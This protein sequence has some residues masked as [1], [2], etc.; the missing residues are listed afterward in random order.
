[1]VIRYLFSSVIMPSV[2]TMNV[3]ASLFHRVQKSFFN[4]QIMFL[5]I[6]SFIRCRFSRLSRFEK[7]DKSYIC[8]KNFEF[9]IVP[10]LAPFVLHGFLFNFNE[11]QPKNG[12]G[13]T[14]NRALDGSTYPG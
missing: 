12:R 1:M 14:V 8:A 10:G 6:V 11:V 2:V 4:E 7:H 13:S 9:Q 5:Q 3:A